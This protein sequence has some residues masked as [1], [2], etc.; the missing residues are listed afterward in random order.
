MLA[1]VG[2]MLSNVCLRSLSDL[3]PVWVS[4]MKAIPTVVCC[5]PLV[6]RRVWNGQTVFPSWHT[7]GL[8]L[9]AGV[10]GQLVGNV[11]FQWSLGVIGIA[12]AVPINLGA[13]IVA[14]A[15]LGQRLLGD[16]V[17]PQMALASLVLML[18]ICVLSLGAATA[19]ASLQGSASAGQVSWL[20][21]AGGVAANCLSGVAYSILGVV[22]RYTTNRHTPVTSLLFTIGLVGVVLLGMLSA[23]RHSATELWTL[24]QPRWGVC[25][26][27][28]FLT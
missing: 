20:L 17:T 18:A 12:L 3:D 21:V 11:G 19:N 4:C 5:A 7:L 2:Y 16:R 22:L 9:L 26:P 8:T 27:P 25:W 24:S 1:A 14:G 10:L 13:M 6:G 15:I 23:S 28:A